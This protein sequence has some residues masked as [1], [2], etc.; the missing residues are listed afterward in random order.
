MLEFLSTEPTAALTYLFALIV[1]VTLHEFAHAKVADL[2]GDPTPR[3]GKRLTINPLAHLDIYGSLL[4]IIVGFGWGKPVTFDPFNLKNPRKDSALIA[5]AGPTTNIF[6][7]ICFGII[8]RLIPSYIPFLFPI[9]QVN[10]ALAV[11]NLIPIYPLDGYNFVS[12]FIDKKYLATWQS[13]KRYGG[14]FLI[15]LIVPIGSTSLLDGILR[16]LTMFTMRLLLGI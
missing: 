7:A 3:L 9:L 16:P 6:I 12:G 10:V 11:F 14:L 4:F 8:A 2:L 5:I 15:L 1:A 13:L